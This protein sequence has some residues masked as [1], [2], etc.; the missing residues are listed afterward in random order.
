MLLD[1]EG[2]VEVWGWG[3]GGCTPPTHG[4]GKDDSSFTMGDVWGGTHNHS[5]T[6][7][8]A[9]KNTL[10]KHMRDSM[11]VFATA[12]TAEI[13]RV[14]EEGRA[15]LEEERRKHAESSSLIQ[16]VACEE[17]NRL[18]GELETARKHKAELMARLASEKPP[19]QPDDAVRRIRLLWAMERVAHKAEMEKLRA[20]NE[21][22]RVALSAAKE[23]EVARTN[24]AA[25]M[26]GRLKLITTDYEAQR[27]IIDQ[28]RGKVALCN[29][30]NE[31][32]R[33]ENAYMAETI[34]T[35][36]AKKKTLLALLAEAL[37]NVA[38]QSGLAY[39]IR[40]VLKDASDN[41]ELDST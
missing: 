16:S 30:D 6:S 38:S 19:G 9:P 17:I 33:R 25:D 7:M 28:L 12:V 8:D 34:E 31:H 41:G 37:C 11:K 36:V 23:K 27:A 1:G 24:E 4:E 15:R 20:A 35:L 10:T 22:L 14:T 2:E 13:A 39:E 18:T 21:E 29:V 26:A 32:F 40:C 5:L 3:R